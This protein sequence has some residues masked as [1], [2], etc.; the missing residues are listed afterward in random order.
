MISEK[1]FINTFTSF[2][3]ELLPIGEKF[4]RNLNL[5]LER[6]CPPIESNIKG[7]RRALVSEIAFTIF[8]RA[9]SDDKIINRS[10]LTQKEILDI[11]KVARIRISRLDRKDISKIPKASL[12]EFAEALRLAELTQRFFKEYEKDI[13]IR[14][15]PPFQGC[16]FI[17]ECVGDI[18]AGETLYEIKS[19][20][21]S[22]RSTDLRQIFVYCALNYALSQY[23]INK[24]GMFNPRLGVFFKLTID[25]FAINQSGRSASE[26]FGEI[27]HFISGSEISK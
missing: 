21:R 19:G 26:I 6:F 22:F 17:D 11:T 25:D 15:H 12:N 9:N 3:R 1:T 18:L 23:N 8:S 10:F 4:V 27:I 5:Q 24:V 16:G 14:V 13:S 7:D 20:D 2:W